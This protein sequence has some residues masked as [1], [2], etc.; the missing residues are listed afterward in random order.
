MYFVGKVLEGCKY[1]WMGMEDNLDWLFGVSQYGIDLNLKESFDI[2]RENRAMVVV[3]IGEMEVCIVE[4]GDYRNVLGIVG[5]NDLEIYY[6]IDRQG[7]G[8]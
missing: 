7:L 4:N 5:C 8:S 3:D 6:Y 2:D 1:C